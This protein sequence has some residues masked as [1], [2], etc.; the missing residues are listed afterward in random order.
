MMGHGRFGGLLNQ[1]T[2]KPRRLGETL[3]RLGSYFGRFWY[4]LVLALVFVLI[5]TWTQVTTPE[6]TGQ[7]ADCFLVPLGQSAFGG[8]ASFGTSDR[9]PP[10]GSAS[11][12]WLGTSDP[13]A[14]TGTHKI[15]YRLYTAGGY[16]APAQSPEGDPAS[17]TGDQRLAG[18]FR[19]IM[20]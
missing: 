1:E 15:I 14:L 11:S 6:L 5:S 2:L 7:A 3:A 10:E 8:L 4:M 18:L 9:T 17:L 13:A 16:A 19:L 12:C 20:I